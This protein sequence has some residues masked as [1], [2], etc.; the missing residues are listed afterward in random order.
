MHGKK[1]KLSNMCERT[2]MILQVV[3]NNY[4]AP[5][6]PPNIEQYEGVFSPWIVSVGQVHP[7]SYMIGQ[8]NINLGGNLNIHI[9]GLEPPIG[10]GII[11]GFIS[12]DRPP[13]A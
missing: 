8:L 2:G 9:D 6:K 3:N 10:E 5:V 7:P 13:S 11:G 1:T 12:Q 4:P